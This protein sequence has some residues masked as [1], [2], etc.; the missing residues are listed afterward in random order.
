MFPQ[1]FA[2]DVDLAQAKVMAATQKP[3]SQS[4]LAEK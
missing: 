3:T 1:A 2:Q 4:I